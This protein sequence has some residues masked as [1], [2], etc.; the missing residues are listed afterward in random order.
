MSYL[1]S[2]FGKKPD[3]PSTTVTGNDLLILSK[4]EQISDFLETV[5]YVFYFLLRIGAKGVRRSSQSCWNWSSSTSHWLLCS[6]WNISA[7]ARQK[8]SEKWGEMCG[9]PLKWCG[10]LCH[11]EIN[12]WE[13]DGSCLKD[14]TENCFCIFSKQ[15]YTL[16][17]SLF[18][19]SFFLYILFVN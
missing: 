14:L 6:S 11:M 17:T 19:H 7:Y 10:M 2:Y 13:G 5:C 8:K 1:Y 16:G 12:S 4:I 18:M 9:N 15:C 3:T